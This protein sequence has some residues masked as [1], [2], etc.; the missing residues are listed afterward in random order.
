MTKTRIL[1]LSVLVLLC[2]AVGFL[3]FAEYTEFSSGKD[4]STVKETVSEPAPE[5]VVVPQPIVHVGG[6]VK[7]V[8]EGS[9][10]LTVMSLSDEELDSALNERT[11][12]VSTGT[13]ITLI[14]VEDPEGAKREM[15]AFQVKMGEYMDAVQ[16]FREENGAE[17]VLPANL[18]PPTPPDQAPPLRKPGT[19]RDLRA[20]QLVS[21]L[22]DADDIRTEQSFSARTVEVMSDSQNIPVSSE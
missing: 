18:T 11:V 9:F 20:G 13:L 12:T 4:V 16:K 1:V 2:V 8:S 5:E 17:A 6:V 15:D 7:E 14:T 10:T 21:V 3:F 19:I 22:A